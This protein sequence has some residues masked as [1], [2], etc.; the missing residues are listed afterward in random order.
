[1]T[2]FVAETVSEVLGNLLESHGAAAI[3][4]FVDLVVDADGM[5][6]LDAAIA[7]RKGRGTRR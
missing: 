7:P 4:G 3:R 5:A 6:Q 2:K 1:V